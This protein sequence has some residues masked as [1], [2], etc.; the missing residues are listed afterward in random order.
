MNTFYLLKK[1][2]KR[3]TDWSIYWFVFVKHACGKRS[4]ADLT[5]P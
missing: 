1:K 4:Q 3:L 2:K 5:R